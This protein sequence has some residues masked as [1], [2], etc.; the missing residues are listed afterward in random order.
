MGGGPSKP[1]VF[2][3]DKERCEHETKLGKQC[4]KLIKNRDLQVS[5][6]S[7]TEPQC[8]PYCMQHLRQELKTTLTKTNGLKD[9]TG[10]IGDFKIRVWFAQAV[11][12]RALTVTL[13]Y[14]EG[15]NF[16]ETYFAAKEATATAKLKEES[17]RL[18]QGKTPPKSF[19]N[20]QREMEKIDKQKRRIEALDAK[21][22]GMGFKRERLQR[23]YSSYDL[24][25][26]DI[27]TEVEALIALMELA[28]GNVE[29]R[30]Y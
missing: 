10:Y 25:K 3:S 30:T 2:A 27:D 20:A 4:Q 21:L 13:Y 22:R 15:S 7:K 14:P 26:R 5:W 17:K 12:G 18:S 29:V 9:A 8:I 6:E 1:K 11:R 28:D 24:E 16:P 23:Q 19:T